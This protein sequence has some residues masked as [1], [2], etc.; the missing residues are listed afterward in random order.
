MF[1]NDQNIETIGQLVEVLKH[2]IG[3]QNEYLR[4]DVIEKVVR[5]ITAL[6]I[7]AVVT[8]LI[9]II[10]IYLS[11]AAAYAMAPFIGHAWAFCIVAAVYVVLFLLFLAF[12]KRWVEKPLVKFLASLLME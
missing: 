1:S 6:L 7:A 11:F 12:R 3:L 4:L 9:M 5:L 2:Y 8:L 10:L